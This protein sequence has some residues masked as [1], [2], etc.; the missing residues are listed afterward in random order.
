[1]TCYVTYRSIMT[2]FGPLLHPPPHGSTILST[3]ERRSAVGR[4]GS[5]TTAGTWEVGLLNIGYCYNP[6]QPNPVRR[7]HHCLMIE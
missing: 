5:T 6:M 1:M 2:L 3:A 7:A 4:V